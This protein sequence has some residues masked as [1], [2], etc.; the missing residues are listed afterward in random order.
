MTEEKYETYQARAD[1]SRAQE[2]AATT[3]PFTIEV[4]FLGGLTA[5]QRSS[6]ATAA[7]RWTKVIVGDLPS[8]TV[9]NENIDDVLI[10]AQGV[11]LD[12]AGK[13]LGQAGPTHIRPPGIGAASLLPAKGI[14]SFDTA[15]LASMEANGLL[16]DLIAHEMGHVLGVG[17]LWNSKSLLK[18]IGTSN[19][20][21]VGAGAMQ[22]YGVLRGDG[23]PTR[24]PVENTGGPGT[25]ESHWREAVFR[26]ELMTGFI[27][28]MVNPLSRLTAASLDD[29]GYQA[30][31]S[32]AQSYELPNLLMLAE[33]GELVA[34]VAPIGAGTVLPVIP[35]VLPR[36][37]LQNQS[38]QP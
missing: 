8:V 19:P 27:G 18:G 6:F 34:H 31:R 2:I 37:S 36:E 11:S 38:T 23:T 32:A 3:S 1:A 9:D 21:F 22:E 14:M 35:Q 17:T 25:R 13:V 15:D 7:D 28:N 29:L 4:R 26:N 24:V 5:S 20:T 30:D 33:A 10:L 16:N 12:G